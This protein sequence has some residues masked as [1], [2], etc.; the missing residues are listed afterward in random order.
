MFAPRVTRGAF[1]RRMGAAL[2][3]RP[4]DNPHI[5]CV[6][7]T[8]AATLAPLFE[9]AA[10]WQAAPHIAVK[11]PKP[12]TSGAVWEALDVYEQCY[13]LYP[14]KAHV[15]TLRSDI[16]LE[17][18]QFIAA[19]K[20]V[21]QPLII[22]FASLRHLGFNARASTLTQ[23]RRQYPYHGPDQPSS[24]HIAVPHK[25]RADAPTLARALASMQARNPINRGST[26]FPRNVAFDVQGSLRG[27]NL[28]A[29]PIVRAEHMEHP[30]LWLGT[31]PVHTAF[32]HDCCD[33]YVVQ[34]VG[35][36]RFMLA[37]PT[38]WRDLSPTC[39]RS[40]VPNTP[41]WASVEHPDSRFGLFTH[42]ASVMKSIRP[43]ITV[44]VRPGKVL[45][46]PAGWF[47]HV[48]NLEPTVM[49][50]FWMRGREKVGIAVHSG[51]ELAE[52]KQQPGLVKGGND[53]D[54]P[55]EL[56]FAAAAGARERD[57]ASKGRSSN[58]HDA[59]PDE[60]TS[61]LAR[62]AA[63]VSA[64]LTPILHDSLADEPH[65]ASALDVLATNLTAWHA[66]R[67]SSDTQIVPWMDANDKA[68]LRRYLKRASYYLEFG[69]GG[70]TVW[71]IQSP[72]L[73]E[74]HMVE[75]SSAWVG[76]LLKRHDVGVA[77]AQGR[78]HFHAT[79]IGPTYLKGTPG[80]P[81]DTS[82]RASWP[83]YWRQRVLEDIPFD[84]IVRQPESNS[85]PVQC[86]C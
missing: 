83:L 45:F 66:S 24:P 85:D 62:S 69:A 55:P 13:K 73:R 31:A 68:L 18:K 47:H 32:H 27:L 72:N 59:S 79:D 74:I 1:G 30:H 37:P 38:A 25:A 3:S 71:A 52:R 78:M 65:L 81:S 48:T 28:S 77:I 50:N 15:P 33:N 82:K 12:L 6:S 76:E 40:G 4:T 2:S 21:G 39:N 36:K 60:K 75:S 54:L 19:F 67:T 58:T 63:R 22:D 34:L 44:D 10:K 9:D 80:G 86:R 70:S 14:P 56:P 20:A 8:P 23:L 53:T 35:T 57:H 17:P 49:A 7:P 43:T 51:V 41:C 84:L 42:A 11:Y 29:P 64:L 61:A 26:T 46:M 16:P 5:R